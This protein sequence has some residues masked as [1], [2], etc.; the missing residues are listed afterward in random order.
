MNSLSILVA[1]RN[2]L[3][4]GIRSP[5]ILSS[6]KIPYYQQSRNVTTTRRQKSSGRSHRK[7][8]VSEADIPQKSFGASMAPVV[9]LPVMFLMYG[10]S[11]NYF[12]NRQLRLNEELRQQMEKEYDKKELEFEPIL[13]HCVIRRTRDV[14][15]CLSNIKV[16]DVVQVLYEGVGPNQ[17]Y[18]LCRFPADEPHAM[19]TIGWFPTRWLQKLE[20]YERMIQQSHVPK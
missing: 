6:C 3:V 4:I 19:D 2:R 8:P 18:N 9:M 16:G 17:E 13:F 5:K 20:D 12:Q 14:T 7:S 11:E 15:H 10:I 1:S